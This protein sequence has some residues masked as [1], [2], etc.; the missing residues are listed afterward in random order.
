[1]RRT[2]GTSLRWRPR[3]LTLV[4]VLAG[5]VL[6]GTLLV[7]IILADARAT[8]QA[9]K[10]SVRLQACRI[11]EGLLQEWWP[12]RRQFPRQGNGEPP[13][14]EGWTWR[15]NVAADGEAEALGAETIVL[16]IFAPEAPAD[17]PAAS[18]AV[19]LPKAADES[20]EGGGSEG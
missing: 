3:G 4:E 8:A 11:A 18:V 6:L 14:R 9:H 17:S 2:S 1:M 16:E 10:A 7:W 19:L 12:N 15:T 5:M 20:L 13:G